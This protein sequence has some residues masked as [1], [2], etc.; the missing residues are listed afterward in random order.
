MRIMTTGKRIRQLRLDRD[1]S[2]G[3]LA[4]RLGMTRQS[5]NGW[6]NDRGIPYWANLGQLAD[7][8]GVS[9]KFLLYGPDAGNKNA[10]DQEHTQVPK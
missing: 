1:M 2:Q 7:L 6:E 4:E 5:V 9:I 8:F 3:Q 10:L